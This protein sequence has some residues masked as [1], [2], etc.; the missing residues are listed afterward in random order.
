MIKLLVRCEWDTFFRS[1][2][3]STT[4]FTIINLFLQDAKRNEF[5]RKAYKL[6]ANLHE[7]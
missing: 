1:L 2:E 3:S 4:Q 6:L 7:V 5:S